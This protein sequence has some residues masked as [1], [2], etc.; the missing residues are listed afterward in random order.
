MGGAGTCFINGWDRHHGHVIRAAEEWRYDGPRRNMYQ[1]EHDE[2]FASIRSGKA[3]NDGQ[4]MA[5]STLLSIMGRMAAYTGKTVTWDQAMNSRWDLS[6]K[7][8]EWGEMPTPEVPVPG[9]TELV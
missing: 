1:V 9:R 7:S 3:H 4:F 5:R 6:P 2:L 8:W